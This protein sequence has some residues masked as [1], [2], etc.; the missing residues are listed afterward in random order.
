MLLRVFA[1]DID[2]H[3]F[4]S[5]HSVVELVVEDMPFLVDSMSM[6]LSRHG[7]GLHLAIHPVIGVRRTRDGD[8]EEVMAPDTGGE[9]TLSRSP[10]CTSRST[11]VPSPP[12][13]RSSA[14]TCSV[15]SP[16]CGLRSRTGLPSGRARSLIADGADHGPVGRYRSARQPESGTRRQS[17]SAGSRG[18][19][20]LSRLPRIRPRRR[21]RDELGCARGHRSRH[22]ARRRQPPA[23]HSFAKLP[24]EVRRK[25]RQPNLFNLTKANS[26][27]TVHRRS[28]L[29]YIGVKRFD[30]RATVVSERRFLGLYTTSVYKQ[31][32]QDIPILRRKVATVIERAGFAPAS[33]SGKALVEIL[34]TLPA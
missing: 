8:L 30:E 14:A 21:R 19:L 18:Q 4:A 20:H 27:S 3:G 13:W 26:R 25:A 15:S 32:P 29:D 28:Y 16:M 11:A 2:E 9:A 23:A 17:S 5:P 34:D 31:W 24:P 7:H 1:P 10:T 33:H 12:C 22:P 6:E